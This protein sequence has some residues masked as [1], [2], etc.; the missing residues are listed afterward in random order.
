[1]PKA[2]IHKQCESLATE[3]EIGLARQ[4]LTSSPPFNAIGSHY[5]SQFE[6]RVPVALGPHCRHYL[7]AFLSRENV[8]HHGILT[9]RVCQVTMC[10][11]KHEQL[12]I[13][14]SLCSRVIFPRGS[15]RSQ[16]LGLYRLRFQGPVSGLEN[17]QGSFRS[18]T[19]SEQKR[20]ITFGPERTY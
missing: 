16:L 2:A 17:V 15:N 8:G 20:W 4:R 3:Q 7:G 1:M 5:G 6:F 9:G 19:I 10:P 12:P 11:P 13:E 18:G 14:K